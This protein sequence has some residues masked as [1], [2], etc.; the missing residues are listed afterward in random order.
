MNNNFLLTSMVFQSHLTNLKPWCYLYAMHIKKGQTI[1]HHESRLYELCA[2][3]F[4]S[5]TIDLYWMF[6]WIYLVSKINV[7]YLKSL[8]RT[9]QYLQTRLHSCAFSESKSK[10]NDFGQNHTIIN[11]TPSVHNYYC[12]TVNMTMCL[13]H[14]NAFST[15]S[16]QLGYMCSS[17]GFINI[18][19]RL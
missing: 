3:V 17:V 8:T 4:R 19:F 11:E 2:Q 5:H 18:V 7:P 10:V 16:L 15:Y 14:I 13:E 12:N 9:S 1:K 6:T